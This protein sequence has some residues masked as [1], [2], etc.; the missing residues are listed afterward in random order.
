MKTVGVLG[1]GQLAQ[2]LAHSAYQLGV[3]TLCYA[4]SQNVPAARLSP[5]FEGGLTN[6]EAL[7]KF[8]DAVDVITFENENIDEAVIDFLAARK[9][10]LPAKKA[11]LVAQDRLN[12]KQLFDQLG[13]QC[14]PYQ[15]IES[16]DDLSKAYHDLGPGILKTRRLGYDGKGQARVNHQDDID[17]AY[18][19]LAGQDLI[20][21]GLVDFDSECSQIATRAQ[22]GDMVFYPLID[23]VHE[24]GILRHSICPS[25]RLDLTE[26]A[27][28]YAIKLMEALDYV[29]TLAIEFFVADQQLIA[30]EIA[31]RVHNSGHLTIEATNASQFENHLRAVCGLPLVSP[32][33]LQ[34][35]RMD[36]IIGSFDHGQTNGHI[37]DYGKAERANRKLGHIVT[38]HPVK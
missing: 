22:N 2:L 28:S 23:N 38:P 14:A 24:A 18:Q 15:N 17:L 8:A 35:S 30:N 4:D 7:E 32:K 21:E 16:L 1:A 31:P 34:P 36:N 25:A 5:I 12:E 10:I 6:F 9:P 3:D 13:I 20:Y 37:Y 26:L 33:V 19:S 27:Q 11:I 29:G